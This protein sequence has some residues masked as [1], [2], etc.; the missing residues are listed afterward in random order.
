MRP[1]IVLI[2]LGPVTGRPRL[3]NGWSTVPRIIPCLM[4][5]PPHTSPT[6][7]N[8]GT[9]LRPLHCL[10]EDDTIYVGV[11]TRTMARLH[12]RSKVS[13]LCSA[14][15]PPIRTA[16]PSKATS[17]PLLTPAF[18][19]PPSWQPRATNP[20]FNMPRSRNDITTIAIPTFEKSK[21]PL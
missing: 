2:P 6:F 10:Y 15:K 18:P 11:P 19:F 5:D 9:L 17:F 1:V 8:K 7:S 4:L 3:P 21:S 14:A 13:C 12:P 16:L 20:R